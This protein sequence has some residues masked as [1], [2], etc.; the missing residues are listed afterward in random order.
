MYDPHTLS[1]QTVDPRENIAAIGALIRRSF[2]TVAEEFHLTAQNCPANPAFLD[3]PALLRSL[4]KR[5]VIC[6]GGFLNG[7]LVGFAAL[8]PQGGH[9]FELTR[10][11]AAPGH[12]H[13]GIGGELLAASVRLAREQG[14]EKIVIGIIDAHETLKNWYV[15]HGFRETG[16]KVYAHLL[17]VVCEM[18]LALTS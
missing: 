5:D 8:V 6:L 10:L 11:C 13:A 15:K 1:I 17:F 14:A 3:D 18:E 9:A 7:A 4:G 16:K 12:R 2:V